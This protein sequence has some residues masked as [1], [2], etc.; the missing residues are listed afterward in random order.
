MDHYKE[1]VTFEISSDDKY[2]QKLIEEVGQG[3]YGLEDN[4]L[5]WLL[6]QLEGKGYSI[7]VIQKDVYR[8]N[9]VINKYEKR[10][11]R[12]IKKYIK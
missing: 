6:N 1:E 8:I 10:I 11:T 3:Y 2:L 4:G 7:E 12:T 5:K 9:K